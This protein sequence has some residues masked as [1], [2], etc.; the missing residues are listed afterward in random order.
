[1]KPLVDFPQLL[2]TY[3]SNN[4]LKFDHRP[5]RWLPLYPSPKL[6]GLVADLMADGHLQGPTKW[7]FDYC[8]NS[9]AELNRFETV[10]YNLFLVKG[11]IRPCTTN[12]YGTMNYGVNCRPLAKTLF[13]AG[14]PFGNKVLKSYLVPNWILD[15]KERFTFF[16]RRY[17]DCEGRIDIKNKMLSFDLYKST[18]LIENSLFFLTQISQ[19][20][21]QHFGIRTIRPFLLSKIAFSISLI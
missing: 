11:K 2:A 4:K 3:T 15:D 17:F 1:M 5:R 18:N 21:F 19:G 10:L 6:A 14:V 13:L 7:R 9:V 12:N 20:L 16:V 8:S